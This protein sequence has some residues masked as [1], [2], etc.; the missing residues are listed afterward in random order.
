MLA[1]V[2]AVISSNNCSKISVSEIIDYLVM[3][4]YFITSENEILY[5]IHSE[6][7][8]QSNEK[9]AIQETFICEMSK[10]CSAHA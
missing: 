8:I 2:D 1:Q 6:N 4:E 3:S 10:I 7:S 5:F 9:T